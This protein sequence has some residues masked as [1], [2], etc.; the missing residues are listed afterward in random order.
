MQWAE[1]I[2]HFFIMPICV[3]TG[4]EGK[5]EERPTGLLQ[6]GRSCMNRLASIDLLFNHTII[7]YML[8]GM[9]GR[10][11]KAW[12]ASGVTPSIQELW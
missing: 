5:Q 7:V 4:H 9:I 2:N 12:S 11:T 3:E 6:A 10:V 1:P 8:E